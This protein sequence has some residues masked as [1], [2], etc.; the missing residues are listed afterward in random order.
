M[1]FPGRPALR[2]TP[3]FTCKARLNDWPPTNE[4]GHTSAP[5]L[6]QGFVGRRPHWAAFRGLDCCFNR[7]TSART[8]TT[9]GSF[10]PW[11][12]R[13]VAASGVGETTQMP[14]QFSRKSKNSVS[15]LYAVVWQLSISLRAS[16]SS[17]RPHA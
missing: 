10:S 14:D 17:R 3:A 7:L 2:T 6:V 11:T 15:D 9:R 1:I 8:P 4:M 12:S 16:W 13:L 5:C